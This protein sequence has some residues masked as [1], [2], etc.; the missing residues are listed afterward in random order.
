MA[1]FTKRNQETVL[2]RNTQVSLKHKIN[3]DDKTGW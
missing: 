1:H 2:I 3:K